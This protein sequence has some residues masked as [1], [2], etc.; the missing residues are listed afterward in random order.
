MYNE[1]SHK[2]LGHLYE[3]VPGKESY[4]QISRTV[5]PDDNQ[6]QVNQLLNELLSK[7]YIYKWKSDA[8]ENPDEFGMTPQGIL[9]FDGHFAEPKATRQLIAATSPAENI[10]AAPTETV[11]E[12]A[13]EQKSVLSRV[14]PV[15]ILIAFAVGLVWYIMRTK[16]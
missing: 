13:E 1:A 7:G 12:E 4:T 14:I 11:S 16:G 9:F 6:V 3:I 10:V 8:E 5:F 2:L 15:I